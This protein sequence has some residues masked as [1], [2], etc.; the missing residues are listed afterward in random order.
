MAQGLHDDVVHLHRRQ[1]DEPRRKIRQQSLKTKMLRTLG[2]LMNYPFVNRA[3]RLK[4]FASLA[5]FALNGSM[6]QTG[7][8]KKYTP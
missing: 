3:R 7:G 8:D 4:T 6:A 5:P 2:L 1:M